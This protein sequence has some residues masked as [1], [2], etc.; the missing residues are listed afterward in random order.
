[1]FESRVVLDGNQ[2]RRCT[3]MRGCT[4][5]SRVVLDGNQTPSLFIALCK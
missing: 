1:M 4:F 5:E 2:T 3:A